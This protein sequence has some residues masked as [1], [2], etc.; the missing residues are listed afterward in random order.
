MILRPGVRLLVIA[1]FACCV[2]LGV[3]AC[4]RHPA[5]ALSDAEFW[6]L[7]EALSEPPGSFSISDNLVSNEPHV[8]ENVRRLTVNGGVYIGVGP[9]Q[10]FTY[11][12][13]VRPLM[14]YVVDIRREN[15][16]LHLF[17]KALFDMSSDRAD[18]VARLFSRPRPAGLDSGSSAAE[19][20]ERFDPIAAS[21]D[22]LKWNADVVRKWLLETRKLPLDA[23]DL[24]W[25]DRLFQ[26]FARHGPSIQFWQ[27][28][29]TDPAP[30]Y[31][32]LMTMPD[33][34]GAVRS[35][36]AT[37]DDF[38]FV[39]DLQSRNLIVPVIGDFGGPTALRKVGDDIRSRGHQLTAFYGS[40][41]AVYLTR[42]KTAAFCRSL[43]VMPLAGN[44][45]FVE[46]NGVERFTSK[47]KTCMP[48]P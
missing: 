34:S 13:R 18:F 40:N 25:I 43:A 46:R 44:A 41:V 15:R 14:A 29:N 10:N 9:E 19:I 24:A 45:V 39:K 17:Y 12:A 47:L 5:A 11:I 1:A 28:H 33:N 8:A 2:A 26:E 48:R 23:A 3:S 27:A 36:L 35:F 38:R 31:R 21:P 22:Q 4:R 30:S 16:T 42:E 6:S 37:E 7:S 32:R 20:F